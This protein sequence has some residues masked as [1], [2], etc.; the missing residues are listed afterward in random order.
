MAM[1]TTGVKMD[2]E[3][4]V[5]RGENPRGADGFLAQTVNG[6]ASWRGMGWNRDEPWTS[7]QVEPGPTR[8]AGRS[9]RTGE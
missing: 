2:F 3:K 9:N 7:P 5:A 1:R 4:N 8:P 6:T